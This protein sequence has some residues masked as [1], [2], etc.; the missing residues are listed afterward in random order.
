VYG[1]GWCTYSE[2]DG[3]DVV[4]KASGT[5]SLLVSLGSTGLISQD[6]AG[7]N[8]DSGSAKHKRGS[9]GVT[10][11]QTT[12]SDDLDGLASQRTLVALDQLGNSG[13]KNSGRNV[14]SVA[15]SLATLSTDDID[16]DLEA[17]LDVLGVTDHVH[18]ENTGTVQTIDDVLGG[19]ADGGDEELRA[20]L[21]DNI[22][23]LV[24]LT[25]GVVIAS[26]GGY[27]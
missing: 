1:R 3:A 22:D 7:T 25:L 8:P 19:N 10:V 18:G 21:D 14:A 5:D 17:L 2:D 6:E 23:K 24:K 13:N 9:N 20:L 26:G 12:G 4:L 11:V 27:G 15:T 16:A